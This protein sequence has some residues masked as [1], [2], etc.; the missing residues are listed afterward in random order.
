[1]AQSRRADGSYAAGRHSMLGDVLVVALI[2]AA[3]VAL[4]F[5]ALDIFRGRLFFTPAALGSAIFLGARGEGQVEISAMTVLGYTV[6]HV[7]AF[8][9]VGWIAV[10]IFRARA[11]E[12]RAVLGAALLFITMEVF[13]IGV[14]AILAS[15]LLDALSLWSV[16]LGTLLAALAMGLYLLRQY[17]GVE[18]ELRMDLEARQ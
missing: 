15:W 4:W 16:A 9:A 12:P 18:G 8:L 7:A 10:R 5:L 13:V 17:P 14:L 11:E 3:V 6:L 2:G 1:M